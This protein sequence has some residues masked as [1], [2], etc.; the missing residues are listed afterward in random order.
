MM[1]D[2]K[3]QKPIHRHLRDK[4]NVNTTEM[5]VRSA[6]DRVS[7]KVS[8]SAIKGQAKQIESMDVIDLATLMSPA[9]GE[10]NLYTTWLKIRI[11]RQEPMSDRAVQE[12]FY[13]DFKRR[14]TDRPTTTWIT[15]TTKTVKEPEG[16][17]QESENER[18]R[19]FA[20]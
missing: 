4:L 12:A 20:F 15:A 8:G 11:L 17:E 5:S 13:N 9:A 14:I 3:G 10:D 7:G 16:T 1:D 2:G 19:V 6:M 18:E